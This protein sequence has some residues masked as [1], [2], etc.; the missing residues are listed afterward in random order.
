[1]NRTRNHTQPLPRLLGAAL[2][3]LTAAL[4]C[5]AP[6]YADVVNFETLA[7][8]AHTSGVTLSEAGYSMALLEGPVGAELGV[9]SGTGTIIDSNNPFSCDIIS[10]PAGG[11]GNYL[12]VTNDGAVQF[13]HPGQLSG[14]TVT[15]FDFAFVPPAPVG[16]G[17]Y[18]QLR[19]AG[20]N[21]QGQTITANL[22]F[23]GQNGN[24]VFLFGGASLD[25]AF[26]ANV[27]SSL[28]ISACIWDANEAC[29]NSL[30]SPAFNQAQFALDNV[31]LN[32]V[33]EPASFLLAGLGLAALGMARRRKAAPSTSL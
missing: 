12:M 30:E 13:S 7:P 3:G 32:A 19:L 17:N 20:V 6:A 4:L 22:D 10:C 25:A 1:M 2:S 8:Q 9:V 33:P 5:A 27:F 15:G 29:S 16:P 21:W 11:T 28:T 14:F 24:G 31:T 23:P 18:G 26:R